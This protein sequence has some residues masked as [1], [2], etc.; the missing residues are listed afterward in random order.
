MKGAKKK[1]A[2]TNYQKRREASWKQFKEENPTINSVVAV[3]KAGGAKWKSMS[4]SE[5]APF[6]AKAEQRK[7]T[8]ISSVQ[9]VIS[10]NDI[11]TE[12]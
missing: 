9:S 1:K 5:K 10:N 6:V 11:I 2:D 7:T 12:I 3:G 8:R 4:E